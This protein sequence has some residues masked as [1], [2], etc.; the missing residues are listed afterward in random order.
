MFSIL[1]KQLINDVHQHLSK[2]SH[3]SPEVFAQIKSQMESTLQ[4]MNMV[5]R[6]EFDAQTEV[7]KRTQEKLN[8]LNQQVNE[9]E[10]LIQNNHLNLQA[11]SCN[12][13]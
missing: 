4:G 1:A 13:E 11:H 2:A 9:L 3:Y 12:T 10:K 7:L 6:S 5:S 8:V